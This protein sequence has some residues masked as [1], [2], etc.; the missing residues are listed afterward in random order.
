MLSSDKAMKERFVN[1][2]HSCISLHKL[3]ICCID[4]IEEVSGTHGRHGFWDVIEELTKN[5]GDNCWWY[6]GGGLNAAETQRP[7]PKWNSSWRPTR[8]N[9]E[10]LLLQ[11]L[12]GDWEI[13]TH[14]LIRLKSLMQ[15]SETVM[16]CIQKWCNEYC[17]SVDFQIFQ[18]FNS[19]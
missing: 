12:T 17:Q 15:R 10:R 14:K 8:Q 2:K 7:M 3:W 1:S 19:S 4:R 18:K 16:Q 5:I 13:N 9:S 6:F 11:L